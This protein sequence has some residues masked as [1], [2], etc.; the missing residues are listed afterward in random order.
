MTTAQIYK[1]SIAFIILQLIMVAVVIAFPGLVMDSIGAKTQV[2]ES[3]VMQQLDQMGVQG[4]EESPSLEG[5]SP[6]GEG[7]EVDPMKALEEA[8]KK[9]Q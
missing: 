2:D 1:G 4:D 3:A 9:A 6:A 8:A 7:Q 5:E